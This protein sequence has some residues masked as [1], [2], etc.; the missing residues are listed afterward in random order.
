MLALVEAKRGNGEAALKAAKREAG[1]L[2]AVIS[3][4]LVDWN[5]KDG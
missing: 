5:P 1:E 3:K 4:K 2:L